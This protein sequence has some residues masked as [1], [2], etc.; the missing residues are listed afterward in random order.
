MERPQIDSY[1]ENIYYER[2]FESKDHIGDPQYPHSK[3]RECIAKFFIKQL[4]LFR[5]VV[6][7]VYY[8]VDHTRGDGSHA[9]ELEDKV[10]IWRKSTYQSRY[11]KNG[12]L[13]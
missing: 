4:F 12:R 2:T 1:I 3:K 9:H 10:F 13:G 11:Q 5:N 6:E 7:V 8:H